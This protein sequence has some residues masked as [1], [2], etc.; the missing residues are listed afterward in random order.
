MFA[1]YSTIFDPKYLSK[2]ECHVNVSCVIQP[3]PHFVA[4]APRAHRARFDSE[5]NRTK[6]TIFVDFSWVDVGRVVSR[7]MEMFIFI[8]DAW[9]QWI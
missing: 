9:F 8:S 3:K 1:M 6:P 2:L 7:I 4:L 5:F